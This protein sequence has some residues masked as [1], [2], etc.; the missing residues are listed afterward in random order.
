MQLF[1]YSLLFLVLLYLIYILKTILKF[2]TLSAQKQ[3]AAA[4]VHDE[5]PITLIIPFRNEVDN[6]PKV[7]ECI[8]QCEL[9]YK[10]T[11]T[12]LCNDHSN[13][14][15]EKL[16]KAWVD[17]NPEMRQ[18]LSLN[19]EDTG[20][21]TAIEN[22]LK[23][24][25]T[26]YVLITDADVEF[27]NERV[28]SFAQI[29]AKNEAVLIGG[30]VKFS[31][32]TSKFIEI[33]QILENQALVILGA[34]GIANKKPLTTNGANLC[35]SISAFHQCGGYGENKQVLSGDDDFLLDNMHAHFPDKIAFNF[36]RKCMVTTSV[37][38]QFTSF[39]MQRIRWAKKGI[40]MRTFKTFLTQIAFTSWNLLLIFCLISPFITFNFQFLLIIL[41]KIVADLFFHAGMTKYFGNVQ[42]PISQIIASLLQ[43]GCIPLI[44]SLTFI[45]NTHWKG[46]KI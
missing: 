38:T 11:Y 40:K 25:R 7:L 19:Y 8:A 2:N 3:F 41:I 18:F 20:K 21:K 6:L 28:A 10:L 42:N 16:A 5:I 45:L 12:I 9:N 1:F 23:I 26:D 17:E 27:E 30:P 34:V 46:R 44:A 15:S 24:C 4:Q 13:D 32:T 29:I 43:I 39:L 31:S 35:F 22:A 37:M 36:D 33:Y 14:N